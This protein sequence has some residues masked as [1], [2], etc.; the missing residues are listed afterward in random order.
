MFRASK[1]FDLA[2]YTDETENC[3]NNQALEHPFWTLTDDSA[4]NIASRKP[5][6]EG[7]ESDVSEKVDDYYEDFTIYQKI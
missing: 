2:I 1:F 4:W 7:Y 3:N 5:R 6:L